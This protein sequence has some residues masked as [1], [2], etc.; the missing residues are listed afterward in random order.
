MIRPICK[1]REVLQTPSRKAVKK[2]LRLARE[3][4]REN[5]EEQPL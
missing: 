2:D 4:R 5:Q 3:S 1:D